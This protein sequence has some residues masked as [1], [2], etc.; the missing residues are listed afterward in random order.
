MDGRARYFSAASLAPRAMARSSARE[1][2]SR[3]PAERQ[4]EPQHILVTLLC[5]IGDTL[6]ATPALRAL[7]GRYPHATISAVVSASNTGVLE[8]NPDITRR[9]LVPG[10]G[11]GPLAL[12][13]VTAVRAISREK[14]KYDLIVNLSAAGSIVTFLAGITARRL[15]LDMP[16]LW[17]LVG[18]HSAAFRARHTMDQYLQAV[19]PALG[20]W[21]DAATATDPTDPTAHVPRLY[22]T[23]EDRSTARRLLRQHGLSPSSVLIAMHVGGDGFGGRKQW[24]AER[25]A[26]VAM[27]LIERYDAHV[28]LLG[29]RSDEAAVYAVGGRIRHGATVLAGVTSLKVTAALIEQSL[30]FIGNDSGPLHM[31]AAVGTPAVGIFGPSDW[32][33]FHPIGKPGYQQRVV[34]SDLP[35]SPCFRF[36]G[37]EPWWY[38]NP[39]QSRAC[40]NAITPQQVLDAALDLLRA[41]GP[42]ASE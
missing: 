17:W 1:T 29:G 23:I 15:R 16:P 13:F 24:A 9:L 30:L 21:S 31:A 20:T 26:A 19:T 39:C 25:F 22:L 8:G 11:E 37:N 32:Q 10:L 35:C 4:D 40:L 6:L 27:H 36:L 41:S 18:G 14:R 12:R 28:L 38:R 5:P 42:T 33:Q 3:M 34:R 7:R 2:I